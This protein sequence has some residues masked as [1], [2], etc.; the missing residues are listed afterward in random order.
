MS[1]KSE[2][3]RNK[4]TQFS[5][6]NKKGNF[7]FKLLEAEIEPKHGYHEVRLRILRKPCCL[8]FGQLKIVALCFKAHKRHSRGQI[9]T[10]EFL[11]LLHLVYF[12]IGY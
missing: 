12:W 4:S 7:I 10:V 3:L 1:S 11:C 6:G 8:F 5:D 2:H 9:D